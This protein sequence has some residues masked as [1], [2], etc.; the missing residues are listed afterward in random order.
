MSAQWPLG[1]RCSS[2]NTARGACFYLSPSDAIR[3]K[4]LFVK[5]S[6]YT[7][8][9]VHLCLWRLWN[10]SQPNACAKGRQ[11]LGDPH[12]SSWTHA[13][14]CFPRRAKQAG[15]LLCHTTPNAPCVQ[16]FVFLAVHP[17][18]DVTLCCA[19]FPSLHRSQHVLAFL[20]C[21][22]EKHLRLAPYQPQCPSWS[23]LLRNPLLGLGVHVLGLLQG[24][25]P[26]SGFLEN[27]PKTGSQTDPPVAP[28]KVTRIC[29]LA[30]CPNQVQHARYMMESIGSQSAACRNILSERCSSC[31]EKTINSKSGK[32]RVAKR[33]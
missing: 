17:V 4:P 32:S 13:K 26:H 22:C 14:G 21:Q 30:S 23:D 27:P 7:N 20:P 8:S 9:L 11:M 25:I 12:L 24:Q 5:A 1:L 28:L 18:P 6:L 2:Q 16:S 33:G 10:T 3:E 31:I 29:I 15:S 19:A